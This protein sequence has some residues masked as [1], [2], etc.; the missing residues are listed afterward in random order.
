MRLELPLFPEQASTLAAKVDALYFFALALSAF[1]SLLIAVFIFFFFVKYRRRR[2]GQVGEATHGSVV[3]E[4]VW[5]IV[6]L[7]ISMVLFGWGAHVFLLQMTPPA[8]AVEYFATAKQWMWKFQHPTGQREINALHVPVGQKITMTMTSE[9]VIHSFYVPAFRVKQDVVPG[10]Y[11]QLWFE[12][13]K[14]GTY[15]LFCTEYCGAEHSQ[16]IGWVTVMEPAEYQ[17]WLGGGGPVQSPQMAGK[18]LFERHICNTCHYPDGSGRGPSLVGIVGQPVT[19]ADGASRLRDDDYLR[20]SI[21]RPASHVVAGYLQIMPTFQGQISE[22]GVL[23]LIA[24]IKSLSTE[25][26]DAAAPAAAPAAASGDA[27]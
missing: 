23:Q 7:L 5:S 20:E 19:F 1:F 17:A 22:A 2:A 27:R 11:T 18:A 16:M 26:G 4:I 12:A 25:P 9:D 10:R 13:T 8:D 14:P 24:Y 3:L 21:L 6:P 15:H